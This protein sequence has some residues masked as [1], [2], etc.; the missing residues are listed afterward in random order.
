MTEVRGTGTG[1]PRGAQPPWGA[2]GPGGDGYIRSGEIAGKTGHVAH[3]AIRPR[4][5]GPDRPPGRPH[6]PPRVATVVPYLAVLV[7]VAGGVY[8]SWHQGSHG[9]GMGGVIAGAA[10][11]IAAAVRLALPQQL[12]GLL[13]S[14]NRVTDVVTLVIFGVCLLVLG[15]VLPRLGPDGAAIRTRE[16][17]RPGEERE[18][19]LFRQGDRQ[20]S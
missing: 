19:G 12:A 8:I 2:G 13:A 17:G 15:L 3:R 18:H 6:H 5:T 11:L 9:G 16:N 4:P 14:R 20:Q 10:F 7:L 1:T